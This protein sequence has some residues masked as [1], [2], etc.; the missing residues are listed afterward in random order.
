MKKSRGRFRPARFVCGFGLILLIAVWVAAHLAARKLLIPDR[1]TLEEHHKIRLADPAE[2]GLQI[3]AFDAQGALG[4]RI[5][6]LW[7]TAHPQPGEATRFRRMR[8]RL[9]ISQDTWLNSRGTVFLLH[10][11]DGCKEDLLL[12]AERFCAA[13]LN[14]VL[15]DHRAHGRSEGRFC[16]YGRL[17]QHDLS[18]VIDAAEAKFGENL[19]PIALWGISL[20]GAIALQTAAADRRIAAVISVNAFADLADIA[21]LRGE[22]LISNVG[23]HFGVLTLLEASRCSGVNLFQARPESAA[24]RL[25]IPVMIVHAEDDR[26]IPLSHANRIFKRIPSPR[27]RFEIVPNAT[28]GNVLL[29]GGDALYQEMIEFV[30]MALT[31]G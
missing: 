26:V 4:H 11:R 13:G 5:K 24:A 8:D 29:E 10:G 12:I 31:R 14:C 2:F 23:S 7:V 15:V 21:R 3:E 30:L 1:K 27:K 9:G 25:R 28:H 17:E 16:T 18:A 6:A 22:K 19:R 20:G